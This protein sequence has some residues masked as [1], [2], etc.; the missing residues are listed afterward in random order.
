[1]VHGSGRTADDYLYSYSSDIRHRPCSSSRSHPG[2]SM[3]RPI[4]WNVTYPVVHGW[5][6]GANALSPHQNISTYDCID[7]L[8]AHFHGQ[9]GVGK[10]YPSLQHVAVIGHSAGGQFTHRWALLSSASFWTTHAALPSYRMSQHT[11]VDTMERHA[12]TPSIRVVV[13]N[14][15][16]FCYLDQRRIING[17]TLTLPPQSAIDAC[18]N[19]NKSEWRLDD[20]GELPTPY[21]DRALQHLN[22]DWLSW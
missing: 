11:A 1:M 13:A 21:R 12:S 6:Y 18:P 4:K 9:A 3:E 22:E 14:P 8:I 10:R 15:R 20:G 16:S 19:Y 17:T 2:V 5:R 7:D